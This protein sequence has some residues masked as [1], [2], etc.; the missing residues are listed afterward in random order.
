MQQEKNMKKHPIRMA[1]AVLGGLV[2]LAHA[3]GRDVAIEELTLVH[4]T[5]VRHSASGTGKTIA[6]TLLGKAEMLSEPARRQAGLEIAL[7]EI[8]RDQ[9][10]TRLPNGLYT[11]FAHEDRGMQFELIHVDTGNVYPVS[12]RITLGDRDPDLF[13]GPQGDCGSY[14]EPYEGGA[15]L[16]SGCCNDIAGCF[17]WQICVEF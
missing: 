1:L 10:S 15:C 2:H 17:V 5:V 12:G 11:V 9:P 4:E 8:R 13:I 7:L 3:G 6:A 16:T 14:I